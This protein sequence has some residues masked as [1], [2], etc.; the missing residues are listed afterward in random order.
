MKINVVEYK[1][2][3]IALTRGYV[4]VNNNEQPK[5]YKGKFGVGYTL[6]TNN[7]NSTRYCFY[8]ILH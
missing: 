3:H 1:A 7:P 8:Y 5:S 2:H 6:R 4:S